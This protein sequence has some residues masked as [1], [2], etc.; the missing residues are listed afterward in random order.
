MKSLKVLAVAIMGFC[1]ID[2]YG[3]TLDVTDTLYHFAKNCNAQGR[4]AYYQEDTGRWQAY[5]ADQMHYEYKYMLDMLS[6]GSL[7]SDSGGSVSR[8]D[9]Q[10][11]LDKTRANRLAAAKGYL[12]CK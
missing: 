8:Q 10:A 2:S 6:L 9:I 1:S 3:A 5:S 11:Y 4:V 7:S 12:M